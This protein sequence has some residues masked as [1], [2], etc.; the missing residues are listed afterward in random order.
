MRISG[1]LKTGEKGG[2]G[3]NCTG[4]GKGETMF[5]ISLEVAVSQGKNGELLPY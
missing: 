5:H 4:R 1:G 3:K 2:G